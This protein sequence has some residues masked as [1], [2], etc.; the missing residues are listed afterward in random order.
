M[1]DAATPLH[2][3]AIANPF[4]FSLPFSFPFSLL[5]HFVSKT[6]QPQVAHDPNTKQKALILFDF[7]FNSFS[8]LSLMYFFFNTH[9][10]NYQTTFNRRLFKLKIIT[11]PKIPGHYKCKG[12]TQ[13]SQSQNF[14][15]FHHSKSSILFKIVFM[16]FENLIN[17]RVQMTFQ[18]EVGREPLQN[19][20][21]FFH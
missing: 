19:L 6:P 7:L 1:D 8:F 4:P 16:E 17:L 9:K 15:S 3:R 11:W 2:P 10:L 5:L 20:N 13:V 21:F 14:I 18:Q 12:D